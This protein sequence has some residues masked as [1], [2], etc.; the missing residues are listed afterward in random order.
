MIKRGKLQKLSYFSYQLLQGD[1]RYLMNELICLPSKCCCDD[2]TGVTFKAEEG[3]GHN[4][5]P[6]CTYRL[7]RYLHSVPGTVPSPGHKSPLVTL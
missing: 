7:P 6:W 3:N 5:R 2:P 1:D 4:F